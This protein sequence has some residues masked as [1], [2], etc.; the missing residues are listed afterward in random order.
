TRQNPALHVFSKHTLLYQSN[1]HPLQVTLRMAQHVIQLRSLRSFRVIEEVLGEGANRFGL[2]VVR[3]S[4][5]GNHIH[6]LVEANDKTALLRGMKGL[7]VRLA[8]GMNHLM[9]TKGRVLG[10]R[11]HARPLRTPT[12]VK[13]AIHYIR[14]NARK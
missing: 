7:S 13:A 4:V 12:E 1:T 10:D 6:L 2:R 3:F 14:D 8:K 11:Y 9:K 5:Q